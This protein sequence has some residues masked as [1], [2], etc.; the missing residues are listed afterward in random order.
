MAEIQPFYRRKWCWNTITNKRNNYKIPDKFE[1]DGNS[2][3]CK[4]RTGL[5]EDKFQRVMTIPL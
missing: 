1:A 5:D 2:G 4:Q 3:K